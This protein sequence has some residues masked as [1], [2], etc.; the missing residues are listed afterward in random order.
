MELIKRPR[1]RRSAGVIRFLRLSKIH[2]ISPNLHD[3]PSALKSVSA[4]RWV[5]RRRII[6]PAMRLRVAGRS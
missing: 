1:P 6:F 4:N 2:G 5:R 3:V